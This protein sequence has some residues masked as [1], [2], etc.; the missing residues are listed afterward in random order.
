MIHKR[1]GFGKVE[2]RKQGKEGEKRT[3]GEAQQTFC[4]PLSNSFMCEKN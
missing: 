1:T 2:M 3:Q 4:S